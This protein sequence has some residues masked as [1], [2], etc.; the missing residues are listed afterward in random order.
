M[1]IL[2]HIQRCNAHDLTAYKPFLIAGERVG[3]VNDVVMDVLDGV[4]GFDVTTQ[5]IAISPNLATFE[6]RSRALTDGSIALLE[7]R[8]IRGLRNELYGVKNR[9]TDAAHAA[10]DRGA[11]TAFGLISYGV[12]VNG[13][14]P[15]VDEP[16]LWIGTRS[17]SSSVDPGKLDNMVAGGQPYG[18]S[19]REN[20]VKEAAEEANVPSILAA[21][22]KPVGAISYVME[23]PAGIRP[24]VLYCFDLELSQ[25]FT[26]EN[27]DGETS[28]FQRMP[29]RVAGEIVATSEQFK[30]NCNLVVAHFL[31]RHGLINPDNEPDYQAIA[32]GL[33]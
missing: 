10:I 16:D 11:V 7:A 9:W 18:L 32:R 15:G 13:W 8:L 4:D 12:H 1:S 19:L 5:S 31:L 14:V 6:D 24:D 28:A 17:M 30:F 20:V 33:S 3:W 21:Q 2:D 22:A 26:P 27:T 23:T 25:E 29:A